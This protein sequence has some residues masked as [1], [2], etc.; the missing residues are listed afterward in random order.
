MSGL[1]PRT[2]S[3]TQ[4]FLHFA[5]IHI[6][7]IGDSAGDSELTDDVIETVSDEDAEIREE[8]RTGS[9]RRLSAS[10]RMDSWDAGDAGVMMDGS[11]VGG[12]VKTYK[13]TENY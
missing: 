5:E 11:Q 2:T 13:G 12:S 3:V 1:L 10:R 4:Q 9:G 7:D 8:T 6:L